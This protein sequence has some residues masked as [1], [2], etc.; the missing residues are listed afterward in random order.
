MKSESILRALAFADNQYLEEASEKQNISQSKKRTSSLF[1]PIAAALAFLI[2]IS[3]V[4]AAIL[5]SPQIKAD[6]T[7]ETSFDLIVFGSDAA[8]DAP[9]YLAQYYLPTAVPEGSKLTSEIMSWFLL[10]DWSVP[11][12]DGEGQIIFEQRALYNDLDEY[13]F[14]GF[15]GISL[16]EF[17]QGSC[18]IGNTS[19]WTIS[20][21][22]ATTFYWKDPENHYLMSAFFNEPISQDMRKAFLMS[23]APASQAEV[24]YVM[25]VAE[26]SVWLPKSLPDSYT[27][28]VFSLYKIEN[29]SISANATITDHQGHDIILEQGKN[30]SR[31]DFKDWD[32][33]EQLINGVS[34]CCYHSQNNIDGEIL[35]EE[36]WCFMSADNQTELQIRF[37]TCSTDEFTEAEKLTV[38][39]SLAP[40]PAQELDMTSMNQR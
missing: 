29:A 31:E 38:F 9:G 27:I 20:C 39:R 40:I 18:Q 21:G 37:C 30:L 13:S 35:Y 16:D 23:V 12:P 32:N 25:G 19:Y 17:S 5:N 28:S 2:L 11:T 8:E 33:T 36:V 6:K 10:M 14:A 34:V 26:Q 4:A 22:D 15:N 1:L 7:S 24:F 3:G